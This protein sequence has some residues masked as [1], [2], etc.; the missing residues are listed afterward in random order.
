MRGVKL[1]TA[2]TLVAEIADFKRFPTAPHLM[3]YLGLTAS[4]H[5]S[6]ATTKRGRITRAGNTHV[7]RVL[8]ES[9]WNYRHQPQMTLGLRKRSE[10]VARGVR[11]IAWKAQC[12]LHKRFHRL[13]ARGLMPQKAA[14]AVAREL[15]GFVWAVAHQEVLL[16][17]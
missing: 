1:I 9:A 7:R 14:V 17:A 6:G 15:V 8:A 13:V 3:S 16:E 12:R 2:A 11:D 10:R 4:E 5:S